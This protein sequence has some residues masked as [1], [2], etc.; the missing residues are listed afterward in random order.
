MYKAMV[1]LSGAVLFH[2]T[3]AWGQQPADQATINALLASRSQAVRAFEFQYHQC[4]Q[5]PPAHDCRAFKDLLDTQK[6]LRDSECRQYRIAP[7]RYG[8]PAGKE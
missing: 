7:G 1:A 6:Q 2:A 4:M 5:R 3:L 8:C